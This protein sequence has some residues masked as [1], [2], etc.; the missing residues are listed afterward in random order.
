MSSSVRDLEKRALSGAREHFGDHRAALTRLRGSWFVA[1]HKLL[2]M[3]SY[4]YTILSSSIFNPLMYLFALGIGIGSYIDRNSGGN[5]L[6]GVSYLTYVGPALLSSA[7][8]NSAF[9]ETTFPVMGGFRWTREFYAM[10]A[11][12]LQP[13]QIANGVM[14]AAAIRVVF[15]VTVFW[16]M[17]FLFGAL[18][19]G[20]AILALPAAILSGMGIGAVM[21]A[22]AAK[23]T[24]DDG[25]FVLINRMVLAP[26][27]LFSGT[28]YPLE[29]MPLGLRWIGWLSPL[30]HA[31]ELGR[32]AGFGLEL[33][34]ERL[35]WHTAY[36]VLILGLGL[37]MMWN[38]FE[39]RLI[40]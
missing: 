40:E 27:F 37:V 7:A 15:T 8:I 19:R 21:S 13:Y 18:P 17:L 6:Y 31:T 16:L 10:H 3:R 11:T 22:L 28:F 26:M 12:P 20:T 9:E 33:R 25:W 30:W 34:P 14:I 2:T 32:W 35:I 29:Q 36:L 23:L 1:Q 38:E 4:M 39:K 5:V 24:D